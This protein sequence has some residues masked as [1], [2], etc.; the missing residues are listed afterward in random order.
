MIG[1]G[2]ILLA[3]VAAVCGDARI[4]FIFYPEPTVTVEYTVA[5][6]QTIFN[7]PSFGRTRNTVIFHF[8]T[9]QTLATPQVNDLV[10]SYATNGLFNYV[11]VNYADTGIITAG[12]AQALSD[13]LATAY[14]N[15]FETGYNSGYMNLLGFGMGA[16][17]QARASRLVQSRS[18]RRHVVARL[19]GLDPWNMGPINS[20][21][22]GTLSSVD[23]QWVE[24]VHTEGN[25]RGDHE[26]TGHVSY[27]VNGGVEQPMCNQALPGARWDCSH[28]FA[29]SVW[30]ESVRAQSTVFPALACG[31]WTQFLS[32]ACNNNAVGWMGRLGSQPTARGAFFL[33]TNMQPPW[34][35]N[36][37]QP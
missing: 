1:K 3:L 18:S 21:T 33:I 30:A 13:G 26:S 24:T 23:A 32:G 36:Q 37:A 7:H 10:N 34:S 35:R 9:G 22:V 4:R 27:F 2:L 8:S 28:I 31:S 5:N 20:I 12:N 25:Q 17:I 14:I 19:T 16:Q 6:F 11:V 29:L 15:L